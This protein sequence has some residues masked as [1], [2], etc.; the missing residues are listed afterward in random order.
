MD[1]CVII[2]QW[3]QL[4][5]TLAAIARCQPHNAECSALFG[6]DCFSV[7]SKIIWMLILS[8]QLGTQQATLTA[9]QAAEACLAL[10]GPWSW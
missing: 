3:W 8:L 10:V 9:W 1:T 5:Q 2:C 4:R 6:Q 7:L